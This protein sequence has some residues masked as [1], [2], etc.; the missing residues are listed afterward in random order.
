MTDLG[1]L[2]VAWLNGDITQTPGHLGPP[3]PE[4]IPLI[5]ALTLA[6]RAGFLT[7]CSQQAGEHEEGYLWEA[8]VTGFASDATLERLRSM[9]TRAG[10]GFGACRRRQHCD[11]KQ[12]G[13]SH[14]PWRECVGFWSHRCPAVWSELVGAWYVGIHD[15]EPGRNDRLWLMLER[16]AA[17]TER[18]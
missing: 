16:F 1:E 17:E 12:Q 18:R 14:C 9:A 2:V 15:P 5:G 11:H 6:N 4:T 10:L 7:D 8:W 3:D 13:W